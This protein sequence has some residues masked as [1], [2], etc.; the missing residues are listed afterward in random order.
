[1]A[2]EKEAA[3]GQQEVQY[4]DIH[5][6]MSEQARLHPSKIYIE[7]P[8]QRRNITFEQT[9]AMCNRIANFFKERGL[10]ANDRVTLVAE[11]SIETLLIYF[12]ALKYGAVIN[13]LNVEESKENIYSMINR[14]RPK[15]VF[16][17]QELALDHTKYKADMWIPFTALTAENKEESEFF[18]SLKH[19]SPVFQFPVAAKDDLSTHLFT[20][21]TTGI[22]KA[23]VWTREALFYMPVEIIDRFKMTDKDIVLDYRAYSWSSPQV[24]SILPTMVSGATLV[25]GRRFSRTR[26][27]SWLKDYGITI[28]VGIP[29]V[30]NFLLEEAVPLHKGDVPSLKFMTSSSA[31]LLVKNQLKFEE[32]YGIPINQLAG[33][34][35]TGFM[36][37]GD[38]EDLKVPEKRRFGTIGKVPRYKE[39]LILDEQGNRLKPGEDGEIVVKGL[40]TALGYVDDDGVV[41]KF[42]EEGFR[43]GDLGRVDNDGYLYITGRKKELVKRGGVLISP[44]EITNWLMGHPDVQEATTIGVPDRVYGEDI[45]SFVVLKEG[46]QVTK[47]VLL[48]YCKKKIPDFKLPK[49][50]Y[51]V[52]ELPR[53]P[54]GK[55]AR[56]EV[57]KLW[58]EM[59]P[60]A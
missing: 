34:T 41:S 28:C 33:S 42:P 18:A 16:Y 6:I 9:N 53:T 8:D 14:A 5:T 2:I 36:G 19:Y 51:F 12:S 45:A 60:K 17:G 46:H 44:Q 58:E 43:T 4:K 21:G 32:K 31:P 56:V 20:S 52:K 7:S 55:I 10:K 3:M 13:P 57:L 11:N 26:F 48:D 50:L 59:Q 25:F 29:T 40:S 1:M 30:I 37:L 49:T 38:P 27:A 22:P 24:L 47:E 15:I 35:E 39:V 23:V 54:S